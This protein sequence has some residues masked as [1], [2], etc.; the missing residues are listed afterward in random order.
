MPDRKGRV[1]LAKQREHIER[2]RH[3]LSA[4]P[5]AE[6]RTTTR[7]VVRIL[8]DTHLEARAGRHTLH[9]DEPLARGGTDKAATPLQ[10]FVAG[11]GF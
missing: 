10:H 9:S 6:R 1:D 3:E 5:R 8:E 11:L 4:K 7:A 2:L